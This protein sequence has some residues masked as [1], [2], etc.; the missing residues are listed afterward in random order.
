MA[1]ARPYR[2][3]RPRAQ[4]SA[5]NV[6]RSLQSVS[7]RIGPNAHRTT[8]ISLGK[9]RCKKVFSTLSVCVRVS[10]VSWFHG[11]V[12][13]CVQCGGFSVL[14]A[15]RCQGVKG[16]QL[17]LGSPRIRKWKQRPSPKRDPTHRHTDRQT[18]THT[19][20]HTYVKLIILVW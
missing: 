4:Q 19:H 9:G 1:S 3:T 14:V 16:H 5:L 11:F 2:K 12:C 17:V 10:W 6:R 20:T 15:T 13:S 7:S 18:H 8:L